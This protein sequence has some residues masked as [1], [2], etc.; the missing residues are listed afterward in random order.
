MSIKVKGLPELMADIRKRG[1]PA[2][3]ALDRGMEDTADA[4]HLQAI[5]T[6]PVDT[7]RL[8]LSINVQRQPLRY[9]V[10]TNMDYAAYIEFGIPTGTG[11][12]GGPKPYLRPAWVGQIHKLPQRVKKHLGVAA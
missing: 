8:K 10:G 12:H 11:P 6:V 4:I 1:L 5:N 3:K 9:S 2:V 7:A